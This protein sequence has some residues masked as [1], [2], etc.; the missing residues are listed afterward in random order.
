MH[1]VSCLDMRLKPSL[2]LRSSINA[3]DHNKFDIITI[4]WPHKFQY[5]DRKHST[6]LGRRPCQPV[7][8]FHMNGIVASMLMEAHGSNDSVGSVGSLSPKKVSPFKNELQQV[9]DGKLEQ[10]GIYPVLGSIFAGWNC[11]IIEE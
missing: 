8:L 9:S 6:A 4:I 3:L 10:A 7:M 2:A 1:C 11:A 5:F